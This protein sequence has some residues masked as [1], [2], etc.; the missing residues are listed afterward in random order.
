MD[1]ARINSEG[2][3]DRFYYKRVLGYVLALVLGEKSPKG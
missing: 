1:L 3:Y 2:N